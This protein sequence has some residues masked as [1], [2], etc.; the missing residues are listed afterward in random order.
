[1]SV[2][3]DD[4]LPSGRMIEVTPDQHWRLIMGE[5]VN[6]AGTDITQADG[7]FRIMLDKKQVARQFNE[8]TTESSPALEQILER[9]GSFLGILTER[10]AEPTEVR[11][12]MPEQPAP[13]INVQPPEVNVTVEVP[14][15]PVDVTVDMPDYEQV[16]VVERDE[17]GFIS[18]IR[19]RFTRAGEGEP[20]KRSAIRDWVRGSLGLPLDE[21]VE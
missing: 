14:T 20:K 16:M 13:V 7:P 6:I 9:I 4:R 19:K 10:Q 18:Q 11:V 3:I 8:P 17:E 15:Q 1:M 5:T 12:E 21:E 2:T